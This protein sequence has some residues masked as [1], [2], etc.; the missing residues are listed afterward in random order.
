MAGPYTEMLRGAG[1][2]VTA[3]RIAVLDVID[4]GGHCD[5]DE[6]RSGVN[7]EL[8]SISGQ[9]IYD[10]VNTLTARGV[11]RRIAPAGSRARY[12]LNHGDNHHHVVCRDC[13]RMGDIACAVGSAPCLEPMNLEPGWDVD[14]AEVIYWGR[15]PECA[16]EQCARGA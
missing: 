9:A 4:R 10:A 14:V 6:I 16:R 15:C 2:R 12:E 3:A 8:G 1:L 13:G 7:A 11:L 5:A